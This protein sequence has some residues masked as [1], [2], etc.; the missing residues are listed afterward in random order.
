[1]TADAS[2]HPSAILPYKGHSTTEFDS[3]G[4]LVY[5]VPQSAAQVDQLTR[6][7]VSLRLSEAFPS[8]INRIRSWP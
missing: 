7:T 2:D 8:I 6:N 3:N 4:Y 5:K 1:M